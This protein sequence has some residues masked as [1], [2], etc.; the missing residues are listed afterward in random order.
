MESHSKKPEPPIL[1]AGKRF[2]KEVQEFWK[3]ENDQ[4]DPV[5]RQEQIEAEK[6]LQSWKTGRKGRMDVFVTIEEAD[7]FVSV[8]EIKN[9]DWDALNAQAVHRNVLRQ[10]RQIERYIDVYHEENQSTGE[11]SK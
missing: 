2:H 11:K 5:D 1:A 4:R 7:Y 3:A 9:T 10:I 6:G 8:V